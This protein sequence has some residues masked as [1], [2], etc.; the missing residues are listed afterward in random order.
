LP[1]DSEGLGLIAKRQ[2]MGQSDDGCFG[3]YLKAKVDGCTG[4]VHAVI[5][6]QGELFLHLFYILGQVE[7]ILPGCFGIGEYCLG[8][9]GRVA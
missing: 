3:I 5:T 7:P 9:E 1:A 4:I 8:L 2:D 6:A